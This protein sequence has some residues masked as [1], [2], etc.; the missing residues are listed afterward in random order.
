MVGR[1]LSLVDSDNGRTIKVALG[2]EISLILAANATTGYSW[3]VLRSPDPAIL[4]FFG[5]TK[6]VY[7][8]SRPAPGLVGVGGKTTWTLRA[9]GAGSTILGLGY[10]RPWE[11][12]VAPVSSFQV[13]ITVS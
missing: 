1:I 11:S 2:S 10:Q 8:A 4:A 12:G 13:T 5:P 9:V 3:T 6:G 7:L